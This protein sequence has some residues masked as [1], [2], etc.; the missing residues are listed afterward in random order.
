MVHSAVWGAWTWLMILPLT[1]ARN[2]L[3]CLCASVAS[4]CCNH[5][6]QWQL[7]SLRMNTYCCKRWPSLWWCHWHWQSIQLIKGPL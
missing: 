2:A 5:H 7:G 3:S 1:N 6:L 4:D